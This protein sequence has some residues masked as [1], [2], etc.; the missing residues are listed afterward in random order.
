MNIHT[1]L[2]KLSKHVDEAFPSINYGGCCVFAS[3]V[4]DELAKKG[5]K[6][7]GVVG[8]YGWDDLDVDVRHAAA[9]VTNI[10]DDE[11]WEENGVKFRHVGLEIT[12]EGETYHFDSTGIRKPNGYVG[13]S[14]MFHV[15]DG[16]LT[17][18]EMR[19]LASNPYNWNPSFNRRDITK[20]ER[21]V[22]YYIGGEE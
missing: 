18:N 13:D 3:I 22:K 5:V 20:L 16:R 17:R 15:V 10:E 21:L 1:S 8:M 14:E 11:E 7:R 12:I 6:A 4:A 9:N 2:E 19:A